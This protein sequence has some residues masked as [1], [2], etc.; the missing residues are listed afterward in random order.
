MTASAP[1]QQAVTPLPPIPLSRRIYGYGSVFGKTLRDSRLTFI[2]I[3]GLLGGMTLYIA[4]GISAAFSTPEARAE[5]ARLATDLPPIM[6]GMAGRPVNVDTLGGYITFKYGLFFPIIAGL[7]SILALSGTLAAEARRGSLEFVAA[8]P[9]GKRRI[10]LEKLGAH[11]VAVTGV[12]LAIAVAAWLDGALFAKVPGDNIPVDAAF[13]FALYVGLLGLASGA[14]AFAIAPFLGRG[15]A[16]GIAMF[17]LFA[18]WLLAGYQVPYPALSGPANL[19]WFGWTSNHLPLSGTA[20]WPSLVL[21]AIVAAVLLAVGVE[22]FVRRDIGATSA[23][24]TPSMPRFLRGLQGPTERSL[25][26]RLPVGLAWGIGLGIWGLV[27]AASSRTFAEDVVRDSP[28]LVRVLRS[29]FPNVDP[30]SAGGFLQL[31]FVQ[32]GFIVVGFAAATLVS[33]WA[34]DEASGRT[35]ILL[36]T[37]LARMRWAA[38]SAAG[39]LIVVAVMTA[40]LAV[41]VGLGA[42]LSGSDAL[43]PMAGSL[44]LGVYAA[45]L[46]GVGFAVGGLLWATIAAEL[47]AAVVTVTFLI[48]II[49]PALQQPDWVHQLALT[50]HMGYPMVGIWDVGGIVLALAIAVGG[51]AIGAWGFA[52]RDLRG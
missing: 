14:V 24:P 48:D 39:V 12:I 38:S 2:I 17:V 50:A 25:A 10:A 16:A 40:V 7:W 19:T 27:I 18:G 21:V 3:A 45:A 47:V 52:R 42:V 44:V 29:V 46:A 35:E 22:A 6:Q 31:M 43:T 15:A 30:I 36:T 37:P 33:G 41:A 32:F 49:V 8:A 11:L 9:F 34:S 28:E 1:S 5:L 4:V 20:D 26:E 13:G 23:V 51:L